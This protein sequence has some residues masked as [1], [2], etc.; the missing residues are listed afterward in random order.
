ML[1]NCAVEGIP[2][3]GIN[4]ELNE[5]NQDVMIE[6]SVCFASRLQC[7]LVYYFPLVAC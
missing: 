5:E 2:S 3:R 4:E 6:S 7:H 1:Y